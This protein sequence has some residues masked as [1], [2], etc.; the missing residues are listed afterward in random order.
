MKSINSTGYQ[1]YWHQIKYYLYN[2]ITFL[3]SFLTLFIF[4]TIAVSYDDIIYKP[5]AKTNLRFHF[6]IASSIIL[7]YIWIKHSLTIKIAC[8]IPLFIS[9]FKRISRFSQFALAI[10][11]FYSC[12]IIGVTFEFSILFNPNLNEL[13]SGSYLVALFVSL[14]VGIYSM[15]YTIII[16]E[17]QRLEIFGFE[18]FL[19]K[20]IDDFKLLIETV[21]K[22]E[23]SYYIVDKQF[24]VIIVDFQ[25]FIGS[26]S[27]GVD[28]LFL[29]EYI[30][31]LEKIA[32]NQSINLTMVCHTEDLISKSFNI[33]EKINGNIIKDKSISESILEISRKGHNVNL[34]RTNFI[35][36]YHFIIINNIAYEYL[37]I[38]F[39]VFSNKNTLSGTKHIDHSK[40]HSINQTYRDIIAFSIKPKEGIDLSS[41]SN[42]V[43]LKDIIDIMQENLV[44]IKLRFQ[45]EEKPDHNRNTIINFKKGNY[46]VEFKISDRIERMSYYIIDDKFRIVNEYDSNEKIYRLFVLHNVI[47]KVDIYRNVFNVYTLSDHVHMGKKYHFISSGS[48]ILLKE[49][50]FSFNDK[51]VYLEN[52]HIERSIIGDRTFLKIKLVNSNGFQT[53]YSYK[54]RIKLW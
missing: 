16:S 19:E 46:P 52:R 1:A 45:F 17:N 21:N 2:N 43:N 14:V 8:P 38:P 54:S 26:K 53:E 40:V 4:I 31:I 13:I 28:N 30:N 12:L 34:W 27:L 9:I 42:N 20:V 50:I 35:G 6:Y 25:P 48:V 18:S 11:L 24:D 23:S 5:Q 29:K 44:G 47:D 51:N 39:D 41:V 37:V 32:T 15:I 33:E 49:E 22:F 36:P 7:L 10:S 3:F